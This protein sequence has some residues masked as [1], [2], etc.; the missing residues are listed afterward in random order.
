[1]PKCTCT[2]NQTQCLLRNRQLTR[3][4][5]RLRLM[6][7]VTTKEMNLY[8]ATCK[9]RV[10]LCLVFH[11]SV[12]S[13]LTTGTSLQKVPLALFVRYVHLFFIDSVYIH[14]QAPELLTL[15]NTYLSSSSPY[16]TFQL[17]MPPIFALATV[18]I[19]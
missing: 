12:V 10:P 16:K 1:M 14:D 9:W 7:M 18:T 8:K 19:M 4:T 3:S 5:T 13:T 2:L 15:S 6:L 11:L 17:Y